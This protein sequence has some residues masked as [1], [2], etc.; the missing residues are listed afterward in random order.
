MKSTWVKHVKMV[1]GTFL[2]A[3]MLLGLACGPA[4]EP[5]RPVVV[6]KE[7]IKEIPVERVVEKVV[8]KEVPVEKV[9]EKVVIKEV[10]VEKVVVKE[11]EASRPISV[12]VTDVA[13]RTVT[14]KQPVERILLAEGRL[15]F[16]ISALEHE[17]PFKKIVGWRD[18]LFKF[19]GDTDKAFREKFPEIDDIPKFGS[20]HKATFSVERAIDLQPD[21]VIASLSNLER[22]QEQGVVDNLQRAGIPMIFVD[23]RQF[24]LEYTVPSTLLLGRV[25]DRE[26]RAQEIVDF[27]LNQI[28]V[29]FTRLMQIDQ[30]PP[31]VFIERNFSSPDDCCRTY[32]RISYGLLI[33]RAGGSHIASNLVGSFGTLNPEQVLVSDPEVM[34]LD[35][36]KWKFGPDEFGFG[37]YGT[38]EGL[39]EVLKQFGQRPGWDE[40]QALKNGRYHII[41][42]QFYN[43]I[44]HFAAL[45]QFAKWLYPEEFQDVD[46]AANFKEFHDR[47]LPIDYSGAFW[48]TGV[49]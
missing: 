44:Y 32:G 35:G 45:Q 2:M 22:V 47:F 15:M 31:T 40:L 30:P 26:E 25:L 3:A 17:D 29:V 34:I 14:I 8:V 38:P 27:Y 48:A 11:V 9:V 39:R 16:V 5:G 24:P 18:D 36:N 6:E 12:T 28:N 21:V 49:E 1:L 7:V 43:S 13:G 46:P 20:F 41:W 33:E 42:H 4:A 37:Y 10:P 19:G 23:Y